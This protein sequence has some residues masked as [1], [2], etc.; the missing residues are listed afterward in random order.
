MMGNL[1]QHE[2]DLLESEY[3]ER[4]QDINDIIISRM[5]HAT[6]P[7]GGV[8]EDTYS[9]STSL[10]PESTHPKG[11]TSNRTTYIKIDDLCPC[12]SGKKFGECHGM[13]T[14]QN[15]IKKRRR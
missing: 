8:G 11:N 9:T 14:H 5:L 7:V 1:D 3:F 10:V 13:N 2:V 4:K 12:G 6:I 15:S